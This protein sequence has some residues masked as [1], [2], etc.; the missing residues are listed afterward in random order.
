M[1][2]LCVLDA[3]HTAPGTEVVVLLGRPGTPRREIRARV[4]ALPFKP[5]NRRTDVTAL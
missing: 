4:T 1:I 2:S 3:A 5:D